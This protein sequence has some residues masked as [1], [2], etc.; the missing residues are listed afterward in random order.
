MIILEQVLY[1]KLQVKQNADMTLGICRKVNVILAICS[2]IE[3]L[4][5]VIEFNFM[6]NFLFPKKKIEMKKL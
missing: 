6:N 2:L 5:Y 4:T 3:W 1:L